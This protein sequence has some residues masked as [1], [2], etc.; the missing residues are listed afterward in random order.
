MRYTPSPVPASS[1]IRSRTGRE[2][3]KAHHHFSVCFICPFSDVNCMSDF[4]EGNEVVTSSSSGVTVDKSFDGDGFA[5]PAI[6]F[7]I[8][9][10]RDE[11][12]SVR[13]TDRVPEDFPMDNVGFHPNFENDNWTAYK[14]HRVQFERTLEPSEDLVTVYGIRI[15]DREE[16]DRFLRPPMVD[17]VAASEDREANDDPQVED[18]T[19]TDIV[20]EDSS[21]V[22]RD[23]IA[24]ESDLPGL[25]EETDAPDDPLGGD[26]LGGE[27]TDPLAE[28][29][30]DPLG[31]SE[32]D[33]IGSDD[34]PLGGGEDPLGGGGDASGDAN[35]D[36][37]ASG[38]D[39]DSPGEADDSPATTADAAADPLGED[40]VSV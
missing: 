39:S 9:S 21:Q 26:P 36:P 38:G 37:L 35:A 25:G 19:I 23:V 28:A 2:D 11:P 4:T 5:V 32:T 10:R 29:S 12:V 8:R 18:N 13:I 31:G 7:E 6:K 20:S 3:V 27:E 17:A 16:A 34:D 40:D 30:E 15:S 22:V 33:S 1:A 24:G 14:D